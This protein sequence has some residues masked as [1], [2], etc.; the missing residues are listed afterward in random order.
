MPVVPFCI[1]VSFTAF[2]DFLEKNT[3]ST[4]IFPF[5]NQPSWVPIYRKRF[6][7]KISCLPSRVRKRQLE[8]DCYRIQFPLDLASNITMHRAQGQMMAKCLVSVD[9]SLDNP[10]TR[11]APEISLLLYVACTRVTRLENLF[12]SVTHPGVWQKN[13]TNSCGQM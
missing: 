11:P 7:V 8:K 6:N 9:L 4:H 1:I 10:D 5:T 2:Q 12:V 3:A 13:R